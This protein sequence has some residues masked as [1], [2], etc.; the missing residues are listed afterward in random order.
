LREIGRN[1]AGVRMIRMDEGDKLVA[2]E[3]L[4]IEDDNEEEKS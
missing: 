3:R 4:I 2:A 1:T